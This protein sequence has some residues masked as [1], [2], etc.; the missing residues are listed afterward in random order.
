[1]LGSVFIAGVRHPNHGDSPRNTL[2]HAKSD[3]S[4]LRATSIWIHATSTSPLMSRNRPRRSRRALLV[5]TCRTRAPSRTGCEQ[6]SGTPIY[7]PEQAVV[8]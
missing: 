5:G 7:E 8:S 4:A 1:M 2:V 6:K 3:L